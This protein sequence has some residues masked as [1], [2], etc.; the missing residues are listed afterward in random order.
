M[1]VLIIN[2]DYD[3]DYVAFNIVQY[4]IKIT[5]RG[6]KKKQTAVES[7]RKEKEVETSYR[8]CFGYDRV[9]DAFLSFSIFLSF[10]V[11]RNSTSKTLFF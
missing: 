9:R 8:L 4:G 3:H 10:H 11:R 5:V 7:K 1:C 6:Q 2:D